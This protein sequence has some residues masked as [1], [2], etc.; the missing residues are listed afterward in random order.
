M[1][2]LLLGPTAE[3]RELAALLVETICIPL[4]V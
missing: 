2:I 1:K 3:G 4:G